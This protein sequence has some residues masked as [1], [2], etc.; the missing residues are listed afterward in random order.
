MQTTVLI[1]FE[2]NILYILCT[3]SSA[4]CEYITKIFLKQMYFKY[5]MWLSN[6]KILFKLVYVVRNILY[7][8]LND[9]Y[10][11]TIYNIDFLF[12]N[13]E[14]KLYNNY[15]FFI[16]SSFDMSSLSIEIWHE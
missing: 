9:N 16:K 1:H 5:Y 15:F 6:I 7:L 4:C 14:F 11:S 12:Y 8:F 3:C 2:F 10:G 13:I